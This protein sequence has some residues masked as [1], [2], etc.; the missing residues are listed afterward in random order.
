MYAQSKRRVC[1]SMFMLKI[2]IILALKCN[3]FR[4]IVSVKIIIVFN[5][6]LY[7]VNLFDII[8]TFLPTF[9]INFKKAFQPQGIDNVFVYLTIFGVHP[10]ACCVLMIN[11]MITSLSFF[12]FLG[13]VILDSPKSSDSICIIRMQDKIMEDKHQRIHCLQVANWT[14]TREVQSHC[15]L[16]RT[17]RRQD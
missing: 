5:S 12:L 7:V 1:N 10:C 9:R 6:I 11:N 17:V 14:L 4:Y 15:V 3:D 2:Q 13:G 16:A 8:L